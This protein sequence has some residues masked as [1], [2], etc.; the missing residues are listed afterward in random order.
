MDFWKQI[1]GNI[2]FRRAI[3]LLLAKIEFLTYTMNLP[4][5]DQQDFNA[6]DYVKNPLP[7]AE[8]TDCNFTN[9]NFENSDL[10]NINFLE[11]DFVDCN[12]SNANVI[13]T[14]FNAIN[15]KGCK[16]L[17]VLFQNC[18]PF[19]LAFKFTD[20][21]LNLSSFYQ[22]KINYTKFLNCI[23]HQVDFTETEAKQVVF[24]DCDLKQSIFDH[25]NL[26]YS[27]FYSAY[28]FSI[29]PT[30]NQIK[31]ASFSKENISGLLDNFNIKIKG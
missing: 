28:N 4:L 15:F 29:N 3:I 21:T 12:F 9:C 17:G 13:H 16:I 18:N 2:Y 5:I 10:S 24:K 1:K 14:S 23:M 31:N 27:D 26:E 25:T 19:L 22:L 20:C 8:Y 11:C 6:I 30:N 7:K